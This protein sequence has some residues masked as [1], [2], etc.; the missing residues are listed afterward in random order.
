MTRSEVPTEWVKII[1]LLDPKRGERILDVGAGRGDKAAKIL[2]S[3]PGT[4]VYAVDPNEKRIA[5]AKRDHPALK[6]SVASAERLPFSDSYFDKA[7]STMALHHFNDLDQA[8]SEIVRVLKPGGSYVIL[9]V[10]PRS[11]TGTLFRFFGR[12]MGEHTSIMTLSECLARM[13]KAK[14]VQVVTSASLGA[15]YLVRLRKSQGPS[16]SGPAYEPL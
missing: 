15:K 1:E 13:G 7:Y 8:L 6:S 12:L 3:F 16:Q 10:E 14:G 11:F 2:R 5:D 4:D 9:E